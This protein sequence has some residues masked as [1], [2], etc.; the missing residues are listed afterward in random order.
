MMTRFIIIGFLLFTVSSLQAHEGH[1]DAFSQDTVAATHIEK[2]ELDPDGARAIGIESQAVKISNLQQYIKVTGQVT[3]AD[4]QYSDLSVPISGVVTKIFVNEGDRVRA[5]QV[6]ALVKSVEAT[7]LLK[8]LLDENTVLEKEITI[9]SK[10]LE[11][12]K[13]AYGREKTLFNE[14]IGSQKDYQLAEGAYE[15]TAASLKAIKKQQELLLNAAKAQL[16]I[17]GIS[18]NA[19]NQA[20]DSGLIKES[21]SISA[22]IGG[23]ISFRDLTVG[24]AIQPDKKIFSVVNLSP[25]WIITDLYQD[26]IPYIKNQQAV[27]ISTATGEEV[28]GYISNIGAVIDPNKRTLPLRIVSNNPKQSLKPGMTVTAKIIYGQSKKAIIV[29]PESAVVHDG[30]RNLV[31]VKYDTYYQP[32]EVKL[33][34]SNAAEL[35]VLEG[36]YEGDQI[37][38]RG[39]E[40]LHSQALLKAKEDKQGSHTNSESQGLFSSHHILLLLA[41]CLLTSLI[42]ILILRIRGK[43]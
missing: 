8:N 15:S 27:K 2:I 26:Q 9:L 36:L 17:M 22:P 29:V 30:D 13:A 40:Q 20:L 18:D 21:I 11:I 35:E 31:Y 37:V 24:E 41:A 23:I 7:K 28:N 33:G 4:N 25:I 34:E 3:A 14:E 12:K 32:V 10:E 16:S 5:G 6:L 39:A 43:K 1:N 42:W 19:I 38:I